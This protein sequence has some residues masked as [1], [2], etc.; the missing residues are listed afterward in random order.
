MSRSIK[1]HIYNLSDKSNSLAVNFIGITINYFINKFFLD[2]KVIFYVS[3]D[4][5]FEICQAKET[6]SIVVKC[7]EILVIGIDKVPN[8]VI[9]ENLITINKSLRINSRNDYDAIIVVNSR[10]DD[11]IIN[12]YFN[13]LKLT[14]NFFLLDLQLRKR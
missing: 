11:S 6:D 4:I 2:S 5:N 8:D 13:Y 3:H 7:V 10:I 1:I 9:A 12:L 14:I